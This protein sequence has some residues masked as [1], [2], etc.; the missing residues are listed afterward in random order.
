VLK[1]I[2]DF[3]TLL[4][5]VDGGVDS[6]KM[7]AHFLR[8]WADSRSKFNVLREKGPGE[9]PQ[10]LAPRRLPGSPAESKAAW[11]GNQQAN[12]TQPKTKKAG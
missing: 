9:T 8:A 7:L 10:A 6:S 11:N 12:L 1:D 4:I 3:L 2:G 5:G